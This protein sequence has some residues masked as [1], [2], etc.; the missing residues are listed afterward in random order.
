[1]RPGLEQVENKYN[2]EALEKCSNSNNKGDNEA[3]DKGLV[4]TT[5]EILT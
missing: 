5:K 4:V 2:K 3:L 1:M